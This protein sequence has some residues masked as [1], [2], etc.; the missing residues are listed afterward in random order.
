MLDEKIKLEDLLEKRKNID[1]A[2]YINN[3]AIV[4]AGVKGRGIAQTI[5][6]SGMEV[7][8]IE[9]GKSQMEKAQSILSASID[10][11]IKRWSITKSEKKAILSRIKWDIS[12][13]K[14][15][16]CEIIIEA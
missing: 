13:D 10:R 16:D 2:E 5:A 3:T 1:E 11:E 4:G 6:S 12:L 8:I 15:K 14:I 7:L 9:R